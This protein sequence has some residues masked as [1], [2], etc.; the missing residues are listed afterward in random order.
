MAWYNCSVFLLQRVE[1]MNIQRRKLLSQGLMFG[2]IAW[3]MPSVLIAS[4]PEM[5]FSKEKVAQALAEITGGAQVIEDN[6]EVIAPKI[7]E[8]GAQVRVDVKVSV[9]NVEWIS[10][11]VE[12]N[13]VP[14]TSKF[15]ITEYGNPH[16]STNVKVRETSDIIVI[17]KAGDKFYSGR[18][19]VKVTAGGCA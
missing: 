19:S 11:L 9:E 16:I 6:V 2:V 10:I 12:K 4:R 14:L 1:T 5:A 17:A 18:E 15:M 8:N 3:A 7:A 13:P